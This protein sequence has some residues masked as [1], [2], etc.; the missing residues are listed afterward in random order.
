M[1][2]DM[3]EKVEGDVEDPADT[4]CLLAGLAGNNDESVCLSAVDS[5]G[6]ACEFCSISNGFNFCLNS[7]Q[8]QIA[9]LVG[10][11]CDSNNYSS[12]VG[13]VGVSLMDL[14]DP[15]D[16]ACLIAQIT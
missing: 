5:D 13:G 16:T 3:I 11:T 7:E 14:K 4:S 10:G 6:N 15:Y 12:G 2:K 1:G 8:A 9:S